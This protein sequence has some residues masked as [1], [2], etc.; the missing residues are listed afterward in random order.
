MWEILSHPGGW[1]KKLQ[2]Y[3]DRKRE[4]AT[5]RKL[6][7][8]KTTELGPEH[9]QVLDA[10]ES[11]TLA[12]M[13]D[14]QFAKAEAEWKSILLIRNRVVDPEH[15]SSPNGLELL[16]YI[17]MEERK[18]DQAEV[19]HRIILKASERVDGTQAEM[20]I[21]R[22]DALAY[23]LMKQ[24]K[25]EEAISYAQR[26][27]DGYRQLLGTNDIKRSRHEE[28]ITDSERLLEDLQRKK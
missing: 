19:L 4:L 7:Q 1:P 22:V 17:Y 2:V 5:Q 11:Y 27:V 13:A 28:I 12:L 3:Y 23:C 9:P 16:A 20:T 8:Q 14:H 26:A 15:V 10:R 25:R 21:I 18:Y 6:I 24:G